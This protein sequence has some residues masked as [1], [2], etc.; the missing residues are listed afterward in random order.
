MIFGEL[1]SRRQKVLLVV[2]CMYLPTF[3]PSITLVGAHGKYI[4][5]VRWGPKA[6]VLAIVDL[7]ASVCAGLCLLCLSNFLA[8]QLPLSS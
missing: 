3:V 6:A 8:A 1:Y 2:N 5:L 7:L 4:P